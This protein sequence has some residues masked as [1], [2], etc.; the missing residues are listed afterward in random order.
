MIHVG[1]SDQNDEKAWF[2][3]WGQS[4]VDIFAPG[5]N[6]R[7]F[8]DTALENGTGFINGTSFATPIVAGAVGVYRSLNPS[9]SAPDV[10]FR[11]K[12]TARP[13]G[14]LIGLCESEGV[15]D[16]NALLAP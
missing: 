5:E 6:I 3:N 4:T 2:S 11:V 12:A 1:A 8:N 15:L 9:V 7:V 10:V 16:V 14:A 13:V